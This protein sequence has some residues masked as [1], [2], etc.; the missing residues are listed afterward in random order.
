MNLTC[1]NC[2]TPFEAERF[3]GWGAHLTRKFGMEVFSMISLTTLVTAII[4]L[5]IAG[6]I[7][8]LLYWLLDY[9]NPPEPFKKVGTVVLAI[10]AV[11]VIIGV[12]LA[13]ATGTPLFRP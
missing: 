2:N 1:S 4:Y 11:L 13:L 7:W 12:L 8:W 10:G 9:T 3:L 6:L 5:I